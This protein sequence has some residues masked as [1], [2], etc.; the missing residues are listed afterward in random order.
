VVKHI[1]YGLIPP[2]PMVKP[3]LYVIPPIHGPL[4]PA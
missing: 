4:G 2:I 1:L 3:T